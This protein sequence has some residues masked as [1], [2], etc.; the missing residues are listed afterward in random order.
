M[1][2][3][4]QTV[5]LTDPHDAQPG[6]NKKSLILCTE[7]WENVLGELSDQKYWGNVLAKCPYGKCQGKKC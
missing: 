6:P 7:S 5:T 3:L 1:T 2:A 4:T